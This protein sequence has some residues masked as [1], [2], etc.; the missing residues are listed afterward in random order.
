MNKNIDNPLISIVCMTYNHAANIRHALDGFLKQKTNFPYE[1]C[2]GEDGSTD[3]T[4]EICHEYLE[5]NSDKIRLFERSRNDVIFIENQPTGRFNFIETLK[6][7]R[8]KYIAIC[9]GDDY[10]TDPYK[11]QKQ[12]DFLKNNNEYS[13]V[14]TNYSNLKNGIIKDKPGKFGS[15]KDVKNQLL[16]KNFI[17]T[18]TVCVKKTVLLDALPIIKN[19]YRSAD[20]ALWMHISQKSKI[21][22][23]KDNTAVYRISNNTVSNPTT[24]YNKW[25]LIKSAFQL[26]YDFMNKY[27]YKPKTIKQVNERYAKYLFKYAIILGESHV[28]DEFLTFCSKN[29]NPKIK[30]Y[31]WIF[32]LSK[33]DLFKKI[34]MKVI[35]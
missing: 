35:N 15:I 27:E 17:G 1:I 8:G 13:M 26:K 23:L 16:I 29:K 9:D 10:W 34:L 32:N 24:A 21:G 7:S 31:K 18:L 6:E 3:G 30:I 11:L 22:Y 33:I 4:K 5:K 12:I 19:Q 14:H 28:I 25:R 2:L 20:L